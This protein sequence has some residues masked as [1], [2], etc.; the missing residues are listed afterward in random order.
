MDKEDDKLFDYLSERFVSVTEQI[1]INDDFETY[2]DEI[3]QII[4]QCSDL[5]WIDYVLCKN[6][7]S[8]ID[9]FRE[10]YIKYLRNIHSKLLKEKNEEF[11]EN[12]AITQVLLKK[13]LED[14][15]KQI[16]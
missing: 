10:L 11:Y 5:L 4:K 9:E 12:M 2:G 16:K 15:K 14:N 1:I 13:V 7:S 3:H 8:D 6:K